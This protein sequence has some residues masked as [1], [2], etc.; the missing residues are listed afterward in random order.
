MGN[1]EDHGATIGAIGCMFALAC[2]AVFL[3]AYMASCGWKA[4]AS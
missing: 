3:L 2:A 1:G 4:G